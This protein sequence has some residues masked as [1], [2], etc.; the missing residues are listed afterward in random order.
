MLVLH[1]RDT[2]QTALCFSQWLPSDSKKGATRLPCRSGLAWDGIKML[3]DID[4]KVEALNRVADEV[5]ATIKLNPKWY[6]GDYRVWFTDAAPGF[7]MEIAVY[8]NN[9]DN[10]ECFAAIARFFLGSKQCMALFQLPDF[11]MRRTYTSGSI[12]P[13]AVADLFFK[14]HAR[15]FLFGL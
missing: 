15:R 3:V 12:R 6:G 13:S 2:P 9:S 8:Y 1:L 7:K 4:T 5:V 11:V 10:G 14:K